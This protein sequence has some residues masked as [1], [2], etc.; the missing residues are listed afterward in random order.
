MT[1]VQYDNDGSGFVIDVPDTVTIRIEYQTAAPDENIASVGP[2][3][4]RWAN[5]EWETFKLIPNN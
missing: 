2:V 4:I 5:E 1:D 3:N